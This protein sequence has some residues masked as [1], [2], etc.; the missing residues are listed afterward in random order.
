MNLAN[1]VNRNSSQDLKDLAL[2]YFTYG[3]IDFS[4]GY[5]DY[6]V[7]YQYMLV[8]IMGANPFRGFIAYDYKQKKDLLKHSYSSRKISKIHNQLD[9]YYDGDQEEIQNQLENL[10]IE[11]LLDK[12]QPELDISLLLLKRFL[13]KSN[14]KY[15][16]IKNYISNNYGGANLFIK[17]LVYGSLQRMNEDHLIDYLENDG[18]VILSQRP[19]D[20]IFEDQT[21]LFNVYKEQ[22]IVDDENKQS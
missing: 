8:L 22:F 1:A 11:S 4:Y 19:S 16:T 9:E 6:D 14:N 17:D 12:F 13:Y 7:L 21:S 20:E 2:K 10:S 15:A 18:F 3:D 5:D